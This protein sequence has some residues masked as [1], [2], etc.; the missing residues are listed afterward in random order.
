MEHCPNFFQPS[1]HWSF[2]Y[3]SITCLHLHHWATRTSIFRR[4]QKLGN[5]LSVWL[6]NMSTGLHVAHECLEAAFS[7]GPLGGNRSNWCYFEHEQF[8]QLWLDNLAHLRMTPEERKSH[9]K[10]ALPTVMFLGSNIVSLCII[11]LG[12]KTQ[13]ISAT[14][15]LYCTAMYSWSTD[16]YCTAGTRQISCILVYGLNQQ[17]FQLGAFHKVSRSSDE[18]PWRLDGWGIVFSLGFVWFIDISWP[19]GWKQYLAWLLA[20]GKNANRSRI[21]I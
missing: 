2:Q 8:E 12:G 13:A 14:K 9:L 6:V 10:V 1:L 19:R 3:N 20:G 5:N 15:I 18:T 17:P 16:V 7:F 21:T 11:L 4:F